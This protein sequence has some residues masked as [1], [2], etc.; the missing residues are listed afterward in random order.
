MFGGELRVGSDGL[1]LN[2]TTE[3]GVLIGLYDG[4]LDL[5]NESTTVSPAGRDGAAVV[6]IVDGTL[7]IPGKVVGNAFFDSV[8]I[9]ATSFSR[10]CRPWVA[11]VR[12]VY[13]GESDTTDITAV[14]GLLPGDADRD[15]DFDQLDLVRVL[16][17]GKYLTNLSATWGDGDW[18]GWNHY[19]Q[20]GDGLFNQF[21][22]IAA[23]DANCYLCG[24]YCAIGPSDIGSRRQVTISRCSSAAATTVP[25]PPSILALAVGLLSLGWRRTFARS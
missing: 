1:T 3:G 7:R 5:S 25:E 17:S 16:G 24:F 21:D 13:H 10:G 23:L 6:E 9:E 2:T 4:L 22:V 14:D 20:D 19:P 8:H 18:D 12:D 11:F 15:E